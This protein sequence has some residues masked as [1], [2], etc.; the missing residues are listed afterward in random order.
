M[1]LY[2]HKRKKIGGFN[3]NFSKNGI[4]T[5]IKLFKGVNIGVNAKGRTY[6]S[7]GLMGLRY[8]HYLDDNKENNNVEEK[9]KTLMDVIP[10]QY[11]NNGLITTLKVIFYLLTFEL[12]CC[13]FLLIVPSANEYF[14]KE[15]QAEPITFNFTIQLFVLIA[16]ISYFIFF[17]KRAKQ[18]RYMSNFITSMYKDDG[19][20]ALIELQN[21]IDLEKKEKLIKQMESIKDVLINAI[22][23]NSEAEQNQ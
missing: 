14:V 17:S 4:G 22:K 7:G 15:M 21:I 3:F 2:F 11:K 23:V 1:S 13:I 6:M 20:A 19:N 10:K 16:I 8:R 12:C 5:S 9:P 18:R